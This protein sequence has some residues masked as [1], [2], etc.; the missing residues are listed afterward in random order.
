MAYTVNLGIV[1]RYRF[2]NNE[3]TDVWSTT[4]LNK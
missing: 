2:N 3:T 4:E 1:V